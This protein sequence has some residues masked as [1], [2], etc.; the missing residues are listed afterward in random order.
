MHLEATRA[1]VPAYEVAQRQF[2]FSDQN[3][4]R[5]CRH[6]YFPPIA[7]S[8]GVAALTSGAVT[9]GDTSG[10]ENAIVVPCALL[11]AQIAL[12][13][14]SMKALLIASPRPVPTE[15]CWRPWRVR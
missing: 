9:V 3:A 14:A 2:V 4:F 10:R 7:E 11:S 15:C 8:S 12:A 6:E 13:W 5:L 1:Q